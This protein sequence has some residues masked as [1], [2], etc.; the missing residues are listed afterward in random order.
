MFQLG[1]T[2]AYSLK[3]LNLVA[4]LL[5]VGSANA[6]YAQSTFYFMSGG[7]VIGITNIIWVSP[8]LANDAV[9]PY[10]WLFGNVTYEGTL[11]DYQTL[12][13]DFTNESITCASNATG[14]NCY[15][16]LTNIKDSGY[17]AI[18]VYLKNG[19]GDAYST[20]RYIFVNITESKAI[21]LFIEDEG[22][23]IDNNLYIY[24]LGILGVGSIAMFAYLKRDKNGK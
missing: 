11:P 19:A 10:N 8:T 13:F 12:I 14:G 16:N 22:A 18:Q 4:V 1:G 15:K 3:W 21:T 20:K 23:G 6:E 9:T 17:H 5:L 7:A 2:L 24:L